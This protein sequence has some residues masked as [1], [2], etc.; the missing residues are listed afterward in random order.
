[1]SQMAA[2]GQTNKMVSDVKVHKNQSCVI[3]FLH[4]ETI[5]YTD[6]SVH[7][8]NVSGDQTVDVSTVRTNS[9]CEQSEEV[10]DLFQQ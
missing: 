2:E 9:G 7:L 5:A 6:I 10:G 3:E 4:E 1:M 8:L